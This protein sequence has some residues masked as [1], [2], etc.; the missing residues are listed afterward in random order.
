[1]DLGSLWTRNDLASSSEQSPLVEWQCRV[2]RA[3]R[4]QWMSSSCAPKTAFG[5]S[6]IGTQTQSRRLSQPNRS[7]SSSPAGDK[8]RGHRSPLRDLIPDN[9]WL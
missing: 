9:S 1:M 5:E 7:F 2:K 3:G 4:C 6:C 8:R